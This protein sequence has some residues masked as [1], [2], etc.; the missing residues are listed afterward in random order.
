MA[1]Y[2]LVLTI[3]QNEK[4]ESQ[5]DPVDPT[6]PF[7]LCI[8]SAF[9]TRMHSPDLHD[10]VCC[11]SDIYPFRLSNIQ[12]QKTSFGDLVNTVQ[13]ML[14]AHMEHSTVDVGTIL[15]MM[16]IQQTPEA[17]KL[18]RTP[19]VNPLFA[20]VMLYEDVDYCQVQQNVPL[21]GGEV[22]VDLE[23]LDLPDFG[24]L[25]EIQLKVNELLPRST[26]DQNAF[27]LTWEYASELY[28]APVMSRIAHH[29]NVILERVLS[30]GQG[31][32]LNDTLEQLCARCSTAR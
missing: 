10:R 2:Y 18:V 12:L 29:Y 31:H 1:C 20:P 19:L 9:S 3:V 5:G 15:V 28:D 11:F 7:D 24:A 8:G 30:V 16:G 32:P 26:Q 6:A 23:L 4:L 25:A 14:M 21:G 13:E 17:V 27:A 22:P